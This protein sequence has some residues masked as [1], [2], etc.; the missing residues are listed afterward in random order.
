[1]ARRA[2]LANLRL[3]AQALDHACAPLGPDF[4]AEDPNGNATAFRRDRHDVRVAQLGLHQ[5][6]HHTRLFQVALQIADVDPVAIPMLAFLGSRAC[7]KPALAQAGERAVRELL[8]IERAYGDAVCGARS[9]GRLT[10]RRT[11]RAVRHS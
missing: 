1:G 11:L 6:A 10:G 3:E 4:L 9:R 5:R 2:A 8:G 7:L